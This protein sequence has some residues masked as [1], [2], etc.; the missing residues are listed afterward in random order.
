MAL[1]LEEEKQAD[2]G[3]ALWDACEGDRTQQR[4]QQTSQC[5]L[6]KDVYW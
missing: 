6:N 3:W 5:N 2:W 4:T 1:G